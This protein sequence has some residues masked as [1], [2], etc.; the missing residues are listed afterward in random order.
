[1]TTDLPDI[2][3]LLPDDAWRKAAV[4]ELWKAAGSGAY[5]MLRLY[6]VRQCARTVSVYNIL[7]DRLGPDRLKAL[8]DGTRVDV[9]VEPTEHQKE[10]AGGPH[11]HMQLVAEAVVVYEDLGISQGMKYGIERHK[12]EGRIIEY[13]KIGASSVIPSEADL[14]LMM[15]DP[16]Y[17]RDKDPATIA[18]VTEGFRNL[19]EV[20]A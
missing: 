7:L 2:E 14:H 17:W 1:M 11:K 19:Y 4:H 15:R 20:K 5:Y 3:N 10:S 18:K 12:R 13:R 9:P 6:E 8:M 16:K